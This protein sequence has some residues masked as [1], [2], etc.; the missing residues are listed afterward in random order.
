M[1]GYSFDEYLGEFCNRIILV[2]TPP[3]CVGFDECHV[4]ESVK[5]SLKGMKVDTAIVPPGGGCTKYVQAPDVSWNKPFK[6]KVSD[7]YCIVFL[8]NVGYSKP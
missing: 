2:Q 3:P 1:D 6:Q 8:F 4:E 5:T 7:L